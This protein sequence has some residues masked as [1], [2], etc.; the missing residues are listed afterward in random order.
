MRLAGI[1]RLADVAWAILEPRGKISFIERS[2]GGEG[3]EPQPQPRQGD[4][5]GAV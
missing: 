4:D 3:E 1:G 5:D 2:R